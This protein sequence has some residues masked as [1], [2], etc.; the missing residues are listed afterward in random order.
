M[1]S[2]NATENLN[3]MNI[4]ISDL[5]KKCQSL[6]K[7][8]E[9]KGYTVEVEVNRLNSSQGGSCVWMI[10]EN[11]NGYWPFQILANGYSACYNREI[12][13]ENGWTKA[14]QEILNRINQ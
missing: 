14:K 3:A 10:V 7:Q 5:A 2:L 13:T 11:E 1:R 8:L 12:S 4:S 6:S 9:S